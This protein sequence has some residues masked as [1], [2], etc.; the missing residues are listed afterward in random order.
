MLLSPEQHK[1]PARELMIACD[2]ILTISSGLIWP[3]LAEAMLSTLESLTG[4]SQ[5]YEKLA[6]EAVTRFRHLDI[7]WR[8]HHSFCSE[9]KFWEVKIMWMKGPWYIKGISVWESLIPLAL[10]LKCALNCWNVCRQIRE[11]NCVWKKRWGDSTDCKA[12][13]GKF[14][15]LDYVNKIWLNH[16][17]VW[18]CVSYWESKREHVES[19]V[20]RDVRLLAANTHKLEPNPVFWH[21]W[22]LSFRSIS[23]RCALCLF[24]HISQQH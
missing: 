19:K 12:S 4:E 23:H 5:C 17:S 13:W 11:S 8:L 16:E 1:N 6:R 15:I 2:Y 22:L 24:S 20:E 14:V 21:S 10:T 9:A 18:T 7:A 3:C